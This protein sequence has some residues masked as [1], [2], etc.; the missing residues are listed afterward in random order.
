MQQPARRDARD[1]R[2]QRD[3]HDPAGRRQR[4]ELLDQAEVEAED[5]EEADQAE[6]GDR[7]HQR[8]RGETRAAEQRQVQHGAR[9]A[10]LGGHERDDTGHAH[11]QRAEHP[12]LDEGARA[13]LDHA[14]DQRGHRHRRRDLAGPVQP[15]AVRGPGVGQQPGG[16]RE[17]QDGEGQRGEVDPAP[18]G[19]VQDQARHQRAG[20]QRREQGRRPQPDE[21]AA[22]ARV[23]HGVADQGQGGG[24][25]GRRAEPGQRL[26]RPQG[27]DV[28]RAQRDRCARR[29][30]DQARLEDPL[31]AVDVTEDAGGEDERGHR[32]HERVL[33]PGELGG[34]RVQRP[35]DRGQA[36]GDRGDGQIG[37]EYAETGHDER[38]RTPVRPRGCRGRRGCGGCRVEGGH[39]VSGGWSDADGG[40]PRGRMRTGA[41]RGPL[42]ESAGTA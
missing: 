38:G 28:P 33:H 39:W 40:L 17:R 29:T 25:Q 32:Q 20:G 26:A 4:A 18:G 2:G 1:D 13:A 11:R 8:R 42:K 41:S 27:V 10:A 21:P 15:A 5:E 34:A 6:E 9:T 35:L 37:D 16:R 36:D 23:G 30:A 22:L 19:V 7:G 12:R 24:Q 14:V 31:A 3:E